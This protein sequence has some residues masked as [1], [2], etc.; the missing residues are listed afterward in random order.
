MLMIMSPESRD[1]IEEQLLPL[2]ISVGAE[3]Q[4]STAPISSPTLFTGKLLE[5][6]PGF[7]TAD[8]DL[9]NLVEQTSTRGEAERLPT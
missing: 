7:L 5:R 3:H 1:W 2:P 4:W 6:T 9:W 8:L